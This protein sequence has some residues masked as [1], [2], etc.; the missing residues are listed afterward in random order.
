[1]NTKKFQSYFSLT[2]V[3]GHIVQ[4]LKKRRTG[5]FGGRDCSATSG[6]DTEGA[7]EVLLLSC[8]VV[9]DAARFEGLTVRL[10]VLLRRGTARDMVSSNQ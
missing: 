8:E 3:T 7:E 4:H 5:G 6:S 2:N 10:T 9:S 1:M